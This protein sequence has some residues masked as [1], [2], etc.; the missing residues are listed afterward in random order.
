MS[1]A[2]IIVI[3]LVLYAISC[4]T[5]KSASAEWEVVAPA[6][7][8]LDAKIL[9]RLREDIESGEYPNLHGVL[10]A[11]HGKIGFEAYTDEYGPMDLHYTASVSKSVGSILLGL[12]L[13]RGA[14]SGASELGIDTPL[15]ALLPDYKGVFDNDPQKRA[16]LLRHVLT[17]SDGLAWDE[18]TYPYSDVRND[19][20]R[21]SISEDP[22]AFVLSKPF[23]NTPGKVFNYNGGMSIILSYLIQHAT[24]KPADEFADERLFEPLG[25]HDYEWERL[26]C[27][28]TDTDGGLHLCPRDMAKLGQLFLQN[29]MWENE[30][31]VSQ[32]WVRESTRAHM[33][34]DDMPDY[35]LQWWCGDFQLA[36]GEV[37]TFLASGHG[38]QRI[39]VLP[40]LD[41]AV[42][43]VSQVFD[44]PMGDLVCNAIV[45]RYA[46]PAADPSL[47]P[48]RAIEVDEGRL[49]EYTGS[50]GQGDEAVAISLVDGIL[51][52]EVTGAPTLELVPCG[53]QKFVGTAFSLLDVYFE[54]ENDDAG[55]PRIL[56]ARFG[57]R[58][59]LAERPK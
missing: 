50:W 51:H 10:I 28:L 15:H 4:S 30:R 44:N 56:T 24:E 40:S 59:E 36:G 35:G 19:W 21:A 26:E 52:A 54:F 3:L 33:A 39:H 20:H 38:G 53:P 17:M 29:G 25:I 7:A 45:S 5:E 6:E 48:P 37:Y 2:I 41:M 31:L 43:I 42:V 27:G 46:V 13:D 47:G 11:R 32:E 49:T 55:V 12:L 23:A 8:G 16:L 34:N 58:K 57:F 18:S 1:R 14:I 9:E 22:V